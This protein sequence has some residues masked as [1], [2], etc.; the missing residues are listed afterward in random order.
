MNDE[1]N[2][3]IANYRNELDRQRDLGMQNLANNRNNQFANMMG[4]AN[5]AGM[6]YSNFPE[7]AKIQYDTGT[8]MPAQIKLQQTY[9]TG[10]DKLRSNM[11]NYVNQLAS[12]NEAISD[13]NETNSNTLPS[14]ATVANEAGDYY[15]TDLNDGTQY[16]NAAGNNV[17]FGTVAQRSGLTTSAQILEAARKTLND[18]EYNRLLNIYNLQAN[19]SHPNFVYNVG[20][21]FTPNTANYLNQ[22]DRDFL[23]RLGLAFGS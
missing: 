12:I 8:Y 13:L 7:R 15:Y 11:T 9:Q 22:S 23:D 5:T 17:R 10:L 4:A 18:D 14:G 1:V 3:F 16:R 2:S 19:T 21:S 20:S 6:M